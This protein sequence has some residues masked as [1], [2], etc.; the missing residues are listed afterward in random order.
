MPTKVN[1]KQAKSATSMTISR[2]KMERGDVFK[3]KRNV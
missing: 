2:R 3:L 1:K